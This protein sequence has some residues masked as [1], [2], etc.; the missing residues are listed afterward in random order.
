MESHKKLVIS[1]ANGY[2]GQH[3]IRNA[4]Q[5]G[6]D[7]IG[8]VRRKEAAN[9]IENLGAKAVIMQ[10]FNVDSL[11]QIF[12]RCKTLIHFRGVVCGSQE[13]FKNVNIEGM[14]A[15]VEAAKGSS[16]S[17]IIF[18]SGLGVDKYGEV[19]W[20]SNEYFYSKKE[21]EMILKESHIP[22]VIFRP[23]YILGPNDELIPGII[24]QIGKGI[25]SVAG[26]G[27]IPMQPI[28]VKDATEAFLA[29][30][31][32]IGDD[33]Q[34][35]NLVGPEIINMHQLIN[36]VEINMKEMGFNFPSPRIKILSYEQ[37]AEEFDIC[38]EMIDVMKCDLTADG[39]STAKALGF[40]LSDL[41]C[42]IN[43]AIEAE[44][45][46]NEKKNRKK[47]ILLLS[48]GIDSA[49]T[50]YWAHE[51]KY[52]IIALSFNYHFRPE[53]ER[54][55]ALK[56]ADNLDIKIIEVPLEYLKEAID[57]RIE[58]YPIPSAINAPEGYIPARN[59][60]FYSFATYYAEIYGCNFIIGG[61]IKADND[62]F[63]DASLKF[64][65]SIERLI[66]E[67]KHYA[68]KTNIK[69]CLPLIK[70]TKTNV[71]KL[72]KELKVP[73]ENT[74]SCYSDDHEPCGVCYSCTKRIEAFNTLGYSDSKFS[75]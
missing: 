9:E 75:I 30:A 20:A 56:L 47:A 54:K 63:P 12:T 8:I 2:L 41:D 70:M 59:L 39:N 66:K 33:N 19:D 65:K 71:V 23:S 27:D 73:F 42:A 44:L 68:D 35:Y 26:N 22:Y 13:T 55:A 6:W 21:A 60:V 52:E 31:D 61:H 24:Q 72:A 62:K 69:I 4:I 11:K 34:I 3:T 25:V 10:D 36:R 49:T 50:L 17:R 74:W 16:I 57:L 37:A 48:G 43:A 18:P 1:G 14:R 15:V 5:K 46:R 32:G 28:Y 38:S 7:V 40:K 67:G 51:K 53:N 45:F 58:G 29:A 64:F